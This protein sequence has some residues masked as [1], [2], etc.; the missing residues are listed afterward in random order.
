MTEQQKTVLVT[1][2]LGGLG[3][4][5]VQRFAADG[6][7][8][9]LTDVQP[10]NDFIAEAGIGAQVAYHATCDLGSEAALDGFL[11]EALKVTQVDVVINNAAHMGLIPYEKITPSDLAVFTRVNIEAPFQ[12][13]KACAAGMIY[14]EWG[15]IINIVSGSAWQPSPGFIGYISSKMGLVGLTRILAVELGAKGI[16][17]NAVTPAL[18]RHAGN[19]NSLPPAMWDAIR[20]RQAIKR[21]GAPEDIVGALAFLASD[22]AS[23]MTG[24]TL[25]IDGGSVF[26]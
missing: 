19:V 25:S 1:G 20:D 23:F 13:A 6:Y 16:T 24:Q 11:T 22:D 14:R 12:I 21:T 17:V 18:T 26:L 10:A 15:R 2:A 3:R 7:R 9:V 8:L 5:I 4:A